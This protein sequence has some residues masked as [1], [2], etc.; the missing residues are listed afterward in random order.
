[1]KRVR[2]VANRQRAR[3]EL[4]D[5]ST[6]YGAER[7]RLLTDDK[8]DTQQPPIAHP[9]C[10]C[11]CIVLG[12]NHTIRRLN[13]TALKAAPSRIPLTVCAQ[14]VR[15]AWCSR[16]QSVG[17]THQYASECSFSSNSTELGR[18]R[19]CSV[20]ACTRRPTAERAACAYLRLSMR[21]RCASMLMLMATLVL[22]R[23]SSG[24]GH[25][26]LYCASFGFWYT[27]VARPRTK[28]GSRTD[29]V[30]I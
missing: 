7:N 11:C 8:V 19:P 10:R 29:V 24:S 22:G 15:S 30:D 2:P 21:S 25:F 17:R 12:Y 18:R 9:S 13:S 3:E 5:T 4:C 6:K 27:L 1:M 28:R 26:R 14:G 16:P 20:G 23:W